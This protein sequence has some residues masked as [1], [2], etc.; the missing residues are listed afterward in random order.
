M[1]TNRSG[2]FRVEDIGLG[3]AAGFKDGLQ[4]TWALVSAP[5]RIMWA[6]VRGRSRVSH[7]IRAH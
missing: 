1:S 3:F 4:L 6:F 7:T 5:F 2:N